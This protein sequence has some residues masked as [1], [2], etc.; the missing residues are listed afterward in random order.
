MQRPV[1]FPR[2]TWIPVAVLVLA[3]LLPGGVD[4]LRGRAATPAATFPAPDPSLCL[5]EPRPLELFAPLVGTPTGEGLPPEAAASNPYLAMDAGPAD[6]E[7]VSAVEGTMTEVMAC[8]NAG[9]PLR[10]FAL[11]SDG[12]LA[13]LAEGDPMDPRVFAML[14]APSRPLPESEWRGTR[15]RDVRLL[16]DGRVSAV[17]Q[18]GYPRGRWPG[19]TVFV[20]QDG[21][22]RV[23]DVLPLLGAGTPIG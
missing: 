15:V 8:H 3:I 6:A 17:V 11:F 4:A 7:T 18:G 2:P 22:W 10:T 21:R 14:A 1:S 12:F 5:V 20:L 9:A 23:D 13:R 19:F 16:S